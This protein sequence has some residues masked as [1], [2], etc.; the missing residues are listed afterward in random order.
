MSMVWTSFKFGMIKR[1]T[2][3]FST[4]ILEKWDVNLSAM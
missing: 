2:K 3:K 1:E 4:S